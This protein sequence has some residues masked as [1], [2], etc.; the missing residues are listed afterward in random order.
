MNSRKDI[1]VPFNNNT[2]NIGISVIKDKLY[3]VDSI[4]VIRNLH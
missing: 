1:F 4:D 3:T 2:V